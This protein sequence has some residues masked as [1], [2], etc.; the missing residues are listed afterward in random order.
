M[1]PTKSGQPSSADQRSRDPRLKSPDL[2]S[3]GL[4]V[5]TQVPVGPA[6]SLTVKV[7]GD[8]KPKDPRLVTGL[9]TVAV[10][11]TASPASPSPSPSPRLARPRT[12]PLHVETDQ[13]PSLAPTAPNTEPS[14]PSTMD[15][16]ERI[17]LLKERFDAWDGHTRQLGSGSARQDQASR[18]NLD[19]RPSQPSAIVQQLLSRKSVFDEDSRRLER[20]NEPSETDQGGR[21][22][23]TPSTPSTPGLSLNTTVAGFDGQ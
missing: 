13:T 5:T 2:K 16:D 1:S 10:P 11:A 23:S 9:L 17:K 15:I 4:P 22:P 18:F 6:Q 3:P 8:C 12:P 20:T 21:T 14:D 19:R 7:A